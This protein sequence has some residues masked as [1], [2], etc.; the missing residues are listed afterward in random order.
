MIFFKWARNS[1]PCRLA[2]FKGPTSTGKIGFIVIILSPFLKKNFTLPG[3][4]P[5]VKMT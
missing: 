2:G 4:G 1:L 5:G 3:Y